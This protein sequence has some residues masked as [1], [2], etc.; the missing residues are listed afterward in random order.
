[1]SEVGGGRSG[2]GEVKK[3]GFWAKFADWTPAM[4]LITLIN[5]N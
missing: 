1:M 4:L 5:N 3:K 2:M